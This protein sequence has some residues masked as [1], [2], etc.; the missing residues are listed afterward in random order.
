MKANRNA[1]SFSPLQPSASSWPSSV[2]AAD[3][4]PENP[5][6]LPHKPQ[7]LAFLIETVECYCHLSAEQQIATSGR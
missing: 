1:D 2:L 3:S 5:H 7:V 4:L 6:A